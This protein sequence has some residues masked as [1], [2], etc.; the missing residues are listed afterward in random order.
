MSKTA[1]IINRILAILFV[2]S[3]FLVFC[4]HTYRTHVNVFQSVVSG[5]SN[6]Y[7]PEQ[8]LF[9]R[10]DNLY[11][12]IHSA[13]KEA[14]E[15]NYSVLPR[16]NDFEHLHYLYLRATLRG[17]FNRVTFLRDNRLMLD[18]LKPQTYLTERT[19]VITKLGNYVK[20][21]GADYLFVRIPSKLKDNSQLP[22]A[23]SNN[24]IIENGDILLK[25]VKENG[26][27]VL[28]LRSEMMRDNV[29]FT[30]AFYL[31]DVHW[32][33]ETALWA[34]GKIGEYLNEEYGYNLDLDVWNPGSYE[35]VTFKKA[36]QGNEIRYTGGNRVFEDI[37]AVFP[38]FYTNLEKSD[39]GFNITA[40]GNFTD[41]FIPALYNE[42]NNRFS[43]G[44][45]GL[46]E[47]A[48]TRLV[49]NN[50]NNDKKVLLI[51]DSFGLSLCTFFSLGF[52]DL[53]FVYLNRQTRDTLWQVF[54][55]KD[56][57]LV[58]FSV[59]DAVV[60]LESSE[61]FEEDRLYIGIPPR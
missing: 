33:A 21:K 6:S 34:S 38:A 2:L 11:I 51:S 47:W 13:V 40:L 24:D 57:D 20:E 10:V 14:I 27:D 17:H 36:F 52:N 15:S 50:S 56:Y 8:D 48:V 29:N 23:Y 5:I 4:I 53:D 54:A 9:G 44:D 25:S 18:N 3:L 26:N 46:Q 49:N 12:G 31:M 58:I 39:I 16:E 28:D 7:Q 60:S 19:D 45:L 41:V 35:R 1:N 43:D 59:S 22:L 32:T 61:T 37:T 42:N 30:N 55:E